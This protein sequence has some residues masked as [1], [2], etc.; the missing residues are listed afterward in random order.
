MPYGLLYF[1]NDFSQSC[2]WF[3]H[4]AMGVALSGTK[5]EH[6]HINIC[7]GYVVD[8]CRGFCPVL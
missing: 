5:L 1:L 8:W 3:Q 2:L 6:V 7:L 4:M